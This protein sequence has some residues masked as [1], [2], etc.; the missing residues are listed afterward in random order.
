V[1]RFSRRWADLLLAAALLVVV[2]AGVV[3]DDGPPD[4]WFVV[5]LIV[6]CAPLAVR[7]RR[8]VAVMLVC[9]AASAVYLLAGYPHEPALVPLLFALYTVAAAREHRRMTALGGALLAL[10]VLIVAWNPSSSLQE[11]VGAISSIGL[12]V[13]LGEISKARRAAIATASD[14]AERAER[15]QEAEAARRVAET[16]RRLVEERLQ[17]ARDLHDVLAHGISVINVQASVAAHFATVPGSRAD[18]DD[19]VRAISAIAE[20]S[21]T[22]MAELRAV[23][24]VL[25]APAA[26]GAQLDALDEAAPAPGLHRLVELAAAAHARG[27]DILPRT[28]GTPRPLPPAIDLTAYRVLQEA[29]TNVARHAPRR[30][31]RGG[32]RLPGR[33]PARRGPR[34]GSAPAV[35]PGRRR[36]AAVHRIRP[37]RDGGA[38]GRGRGHAARGATR[39]RRVRGPRRPA[40]R[41]GR[42]PVR[43]ADVRAPVMTIR[44]LLADDQT[45]VRGAFAMLVSS[46]ADMEVVGQAGTGVEA[47]AMAR[48]SRADV[49]VMD[50]RM[51]ELDGI[52]ACRTIAADDDLAGV[53]VL[54][55]TTFETDENVVRAIRAGAS[56]FLVKDTRPEQLLDAIRTIAAGE[57]LLSP[58]ATRALMSRVIGLPDAHLPGRGAVDRLTNREREVLALVGAG[59]RTRRSP[60][61]SYSAGSPPR[62]MSAASWPSSRPATGPSS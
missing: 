37:A 32:H 29:L 58:G 7:R 47:V 13:A 56:G 49:V 8:P 59:C 2:T 28:T 20:E 53:R 17:I 14:R 15:A 51:P 4:R 1:E 61:R 25:R 27:V 36:R 50:I 44:V 5:L 52:E 40:A 41:R 34:L 22:S 10:A 33:G 55:L 39:R 42:D 19:L 26:A 16:Q 43:D 57:S 30:D 3:I 24:G 54:V 35:R 45:L 21:R 18:R 11:L 62:P 12:A 23:L 46:A 38:R 31:R 60:T 6:L 48:E 9:I